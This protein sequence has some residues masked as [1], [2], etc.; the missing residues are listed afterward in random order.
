MIALLVGIVT[1]RHERRLDRRCLIYEDLLPAVV[2]QIDREVTHRQVPGRQM[3]VYIELLRAARIAGWDEYD[4]AT[5]IREGVLERE[6]LLLT[7]GSRMGGHPESIDYPKDIDQGVLDQ[8]A[9]IEQLTLARA[10]SLSVLVE[11]KITPSRS[12]WSRVRHRPPVRWLNA[13]RLTWKHR[14]L[15]HELDA[16]D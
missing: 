8:V 11:R 15:R 9:A 6:Q 1:V 3:H 4:L 7:V 13:A 5:K 14:A 12:L 16:G 10:A 2:D